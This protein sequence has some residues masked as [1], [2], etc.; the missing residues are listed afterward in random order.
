V[1]AAPAPACAGDAPR[2]ALVIDTGTAVEEMCVRLDDE[3]VTG[4]ELIELAADQHGLEYGLGFGGQAVCMLAGVGPTGD[5]CFADYPN[6]W[7][8]WRATG[9]GE[10]AW[11]ATGAATTAVEDGDVQGWAWGSG[12]GAE[13]HPRPPDTEFSEVC[14]ATGGGPAEQAT[15]SPAA[16]GPEPSPSQDAA[17]R[18]AGDATGQPRGGRRPRSGAPVP[19]EAAPAPDRRWYEGALAAELP[20]P[21]PIPTPPATPPSP[22]P[23]ALAAD[24]ATDHG[25]PPAGIVAVVAAG[26]LFAIGAFLTVRRRP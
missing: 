2:A 10:W 3:T 19:A 4:L 12:D 8:Y 21:T 20:P 23:P 16:P 18:T 24:R 17:E 7:G 25:P 11:S 1:A 14:A 6:F 5:D 9:S 15:P 13:D 22:A 26:A